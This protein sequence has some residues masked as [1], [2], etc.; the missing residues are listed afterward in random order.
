MVFL[1]FAPPELE[2]ERIPRPPGEHV[3]QCLCGGRKAQAPV[4]CPRW[5]DVSCEYHGVNAFVG[6]S[7]GI[8]SSWGAIVFPSFLC[9]KNAVLSSGIEACLFSEKQGEAVWFYN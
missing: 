7:P 3:S 8:V 2:P 1:L 9:F 4:T 6:W 5:Y